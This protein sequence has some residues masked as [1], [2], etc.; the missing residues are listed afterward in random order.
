MRIRIRVLAMKHLTS[1]LLL[2]SLLVL[3]SARA[4]QAG[5]ASGAGAP[6]AV[7]EAPSSSVTH[8]GSRPSSTGPAQHFTGSVRIDPLFQPREPSR[9]SGASVTFEPGARTAWHS[10]GLKRLIF[11]S[12]MGIYGEV[13]GEEYGSQLDPYRD[14]A[15]VIEAS[16]LDYTS[17]G[18]AGSPTTRK[19]TTRSRRRAS[20]SRDTTCR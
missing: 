4:D 6:P 1:K 19:S 20:R 17:C 5:H 3:D 10:A 15:A 2:L 9:V 7:Q 11:I 18:L 8:A 14:S 13:P 12:S 16:D